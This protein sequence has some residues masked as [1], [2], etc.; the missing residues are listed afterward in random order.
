MQ[1]LSAILVAL[2]I[3]LGAT[4]TQAQTTQPNLIVRDASS[5]LVTTCAF[6]QGGAVFPCHLVYGA[7][8]TGALHVILTDTS[9]RPIVSITGSV[10]IQGGNTVAV[11]VDGSGVVQPISAAS[12][13][14]PANA[15]QEAGGN[16]AAAAASAASIATNT[17]SKLTG[18]AS[19]NNS[20]TITTGG[21][22]QTLLASNASRKGCLIQNPPTATENLAVFVGATGSAT[23]V[24]AFTLPPGGTFQCLSGPLVITDN[25]A[26]EAA[27][28]GHAF[29]ETDQ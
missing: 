2:G 16:L 21:A 15:A 29:A 4:P 24:H 14:L 10:T 9:G 11:K 8:N 26:V 6:S 1:K 5:A 20:T 27:T 3:A 7:D 12:L 18:A 25:I 28:P 13:P 19:N 22:F 17:A 23:T